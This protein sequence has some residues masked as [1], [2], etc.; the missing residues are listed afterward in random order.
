MPADVQGPS[1]ADLISSVRGGAVS[2]YG[3]LYERHVVAA[4]NLARQLARSPAEADDLVSEAFAKVLD[5]LRQG[6]GPDAAFRAYLLTALRHT[7]YDKTRRE[8]KVELTEDVTQVS[9]VKPESVTVPFADPAVAGLERTMAARAFAALPERWQAVLWHTEVERQSPAQV[10]PLLGL[11][12][13]GVSALAYR[14]R[15]G[16]RQAYLQV[17][18]AGSSDEACRA[19]AD[20]LGAWVR[21]GLSTRE[22]AQVESHLDGCARCRALAAELTE[23]NG[24]LSAVV[25]PVVLGPLAAAYLA[26][27]A[28]TTGLVAGGSGGLAAGAVATGARQGVLAGV[29]GAVVAAAVA[30]GVAATPVNLDAPLSVADGPPATSQQAPP[31]TPPASPPA[32]APPPSDAPPPTS[33]RTPPVPQVPEQSGQAAPPTPTSP[34]STPPPPPAPSPA[35]LEVTGPNTPPVLEPGTPADLVFTVRNTGGTTS[36][37]VTIAL[38]LPDGVRS[39]G[40][41]AAGCAGVRELVCQGP[42]IE[43]GAMS[44]FTLSL[45]AE[46][47]GVDGVITGTA[48]AGGARGTA[49][50][51][52]VRV[53]PPVGVDRVE[54]TIAQRAGVWHDGPAVDVVVRNT[55]NTAQVVALDFDRPLRG[56]EAPGLDCGER[57][58]VSRAPLAPGRALSLTAHVHRLPWPDQEVTVTATLG[59]AT[60]SASLWLLWLPGLDS[61]LFLENRADRTG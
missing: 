47:G 13:N 36:G 8:R 56:A 14:A 2:A 37:P 7:A 41:R 39:S 17:H 16:L 45:V 20:R 52:S 27:S 15:E 24:S 25:A 23:V 58:C 54:V 6:K 12:P 53:R 21:G 48:G 11:S 43:P 9:G 33:A 60:D 57:R 46:P 19:T 32:T 5:A 44:R 40:A 55:G 61:L 34:L 22:R 29:S 50:R 3:E 49:V 10:G 42:G 18:L 31:P 35:A 51:I 1:D 4:R 28:A 38:S 59:A 30:V 26:S